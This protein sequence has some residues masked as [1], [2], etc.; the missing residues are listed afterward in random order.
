MHTGENLSLKHIN[1]TET[2]EVRAEGRQLCFF[3]LKKGKCKYLAEQVSHVLSSGDW[4][5]FSKVRGGKVEPMD[6]KGTTAVRFLVGV[7]QLGSLLGL[8]EIGLLEKVSATL[9]DG[10]HHPSTSPLARQCQT[11][12]D[13]TPA[14]STLEQRSH[15]LRIAAAILA[16]EFKA[17]KEQQTKSGH[18]HADLAAMF[19]QLSMEDVEKL[20]VEDLAKKMGYSRRHLNRLFQEHMGISA[21]DLKMEVRLLKAVSLLKN[22]AVK[23]IDVALECGFNHLGL[24]SQ[25]FKRRFGVSPREW[26]QQEVAR[27]KGPAQSAKQDC[28]LLSNG[29]CLWKKM[30]HQHGEL[31]ALAS[32]PV[33]ARASACK[34]SSRAA[35]RVPAL[36]GAEQQN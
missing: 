22:P 26:R 23:V 11:L 4:L 34:A 36:K 17:A 30:N 15:L 14:S 18:G 31:P 25:C 24:F 5:V 1:I 20:S 12:L 33:P 29:M 28:Q 35:S 27:T 32:C 21:S 3:H 13:S 10:R 16:E 7:D 8:N 19:N 6:K 9:N 2:C